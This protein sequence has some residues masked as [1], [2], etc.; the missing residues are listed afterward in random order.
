MYLNEKKSAAF[1][2]SVFNC[3]T[4]KVNYWLKKY[5][6]EK[7]TINEAIY[8]HKNPNDN[9]FNINEMVTKEDHFLFD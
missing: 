8:L 1:I 6:I 9:P 4:S 3:S 7:R 5:C 2:A